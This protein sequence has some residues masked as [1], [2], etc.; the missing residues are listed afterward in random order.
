MPNMSYCRFENTFHDLQDCLRAVDDLVETYADGEPDPLSRTE[1]SHRAALYE[2]CKSYMEACE[3]LDE[4]QMDY[5][6]SQKVA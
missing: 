1:E 3:E 6:R 5:N 4:I 2:L